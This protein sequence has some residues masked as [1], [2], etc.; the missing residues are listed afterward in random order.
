MNGEIA[1]RLLKAARGAETGDIRL[2]GS[3]HGAPQRS[4]GHD[5]VKSGRA[6]PTGAIR[7]PTRVV[8]L[9]KRLALHL[10][11]LRETRGKIPVQAHSICAGAGRVVTCPGLC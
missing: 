1:K 6:R 5:F 3:L 10:P 7:A 8:H 4:T 2:P 11:G 9:P